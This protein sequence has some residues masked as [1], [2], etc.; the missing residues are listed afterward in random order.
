MTEYNDIGISRQLDWARI[1]K[2][3]SIG[4][5]GGVL[6]LIGD[7][8]LGW[9]VEDET[10]EGVLR[11]MSAYTGTSDGGILTV[12]IL[13]LFGMVLEGLSLFGIYRLM[14]EQSPKHAHRFRAGICEGADTLS[15]V[16]L[17]LLNAGGNDRSDDPRSRVQYSSVQSHYL[18][19]DRHRKCVDVRRPACDVE[20]SAEV[21]LT[22]IWST[23]PW[24]EH[25]Y[26]RCRSVRK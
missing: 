18:C 9:G 12:T 25:L 22:T 5:F 6:H 7:M 21:R 23:A 15:K 11:M 17:D 24:S 20:K 1:R 2:L 8:I 16:V 13:G 3:L 26:W 10:M 19:L 14:A 4:L